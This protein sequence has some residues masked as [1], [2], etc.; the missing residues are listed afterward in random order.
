M[1]ALSALSRTLAPLMG[2]GLGLLS[3]RRLPRQAGRLSLAGLQAPVEIIRDSWG[4]PHIY[5]TNNHDLMFAQGFVHA[6]DRL[7]QMDFN[8]RLV[9]GRLAE[10][11][12]AVALPVDR[13]MRTIGMR[14]A[15]EQD[16]ALISAGTRDELEAYAAGVSAY[17]AQGPLPVECALLRYQPEPWMVADTLSWIKMMSWSLSVNWET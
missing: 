14:R 3:R 5:A 4:V 17:I 6:Q 13:W 9:S 1:P 7:W 10:V 11:L 2:A 12:G 15:A 8:R 16:V